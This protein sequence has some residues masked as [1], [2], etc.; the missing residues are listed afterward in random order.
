MASEAVLFFSLWLQRPLQI[1]A[2]SPS[3]SHLANAMAGLIDLNRPGLVLELGAGTGSL[4][5]GL[6]RAGCPP[7]RLVIVEREPALADGLRRNFP[8][9]RT[10]TGDATRLADLFV[11]R[12]ITRLC[13]VVSSLPIKWFSPI[14]QRRVVE[15]CL[16]RLGPGGRFLQLT[17]AFASPLA[18]NALGIRGACVAHVWRNLPPG[19]IWAYSAGDGA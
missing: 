12:G 5:R 19:Q 7:D 11:E 16:G 2:V 4:T 3:S 17:N 10:V 9:I 1:A 6:L 18:M 14:D 15:P 13:A 8:S